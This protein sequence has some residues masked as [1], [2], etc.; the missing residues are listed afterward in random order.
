MRGKLSKILHFDE[1]DVVF[2]V[3][4]ISPVINSVK[5]LLILLL[6]WQQ[7]PLLV[8][9]SLSCIAAILGNEGEIKPEQE[10]GSR[11]SEDRDTQNCLDFAIWT[12]VWPKDTG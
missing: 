10:P 6:Q 2:P 7:L 12:L 3:D 9:K 1:V 11:E 4:Q 5:S 8:G